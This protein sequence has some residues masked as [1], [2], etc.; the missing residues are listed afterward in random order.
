LKKQ[1]RHSGARDCSFNAILELMCI[2]SASF[3]T[4]IEQ[5]GSISTFLKFISLSPAFSEVS[6]VVGEIFLRTTVVVVLG[7]PATD[8][9]VLRDAI[10]R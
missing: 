8:G 2:A 9:R 1:R 3:L 4:W 6:V 5:P 7:S 10:S